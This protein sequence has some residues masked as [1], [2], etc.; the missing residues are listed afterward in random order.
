MGKLTSLIVGIFLIW[1]SQNIG[2]SPDSAEGVVTF[3]VVGAGIVLSSIVLFL[4][5]LFGGDK[6][7]KYPPLS[8]AKPKPPG[9]N[10]YWPPGYKGPRKPYPGDRRRR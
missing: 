6:P 9:I 7:Q 1:L 2:D 10:Q 5:S 8:E 4:E 3:F